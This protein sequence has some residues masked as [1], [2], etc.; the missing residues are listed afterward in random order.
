MKLFQILISIIILTFYSSNSFAIKIKTSG[1]E[2]IKN[3]DINAARKRA[4]INALKNA[5]SQSGDILINENALINELEINQLSTSTLINLN[6]IQIKNETIKNGFIKL[7]LEILIHSKN[8]FQCHHI[9]LKSNLLIPQSTI[10]NRAQL[11]FGNLQNFESNITEKFGDMLNHLSR[12][13]NGY[14]YSKYNLNLNHESSEFNSDI[15]AVWA[16][17]TKQPQY[18]LASNITDISLNRS[19]FLLNK[20]FPQYHR[21]FNMDFSLYHG[22]TGE[23]VWQSNYP[24]SAK[25][26]F[27]KNETVMPDSNEFWQSSYGKNIQ[28]IFSN[29][30]KDLDSFLD[31]KSVIGKVIAKN[32]QQLI[33]N[34]GR[35][36]G[37]KE[38]DDIEL[39]LNQNIV[40]KYGLVRPIAN[41]TN[42]ILNVNQVTELTASGTLTAEDAIENIQLNDF[43]I[44]KV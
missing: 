2:N 44:P 19:N 21:N 37:I 35:K 8:K 11:R 27:S 20:L 26:T 28:Q 40:D 16:A 13:S 14:V 15:I 4:F 36:H 41:K 32:Q 38:N 17:N 33:I 30:I 25:W 9:N 31:C 29:V 12:K 23:L 6:Q 5:N 18:I 3:N 7:D 24:S 39:V 1:F 10:D 42:V 34:L 43:A 22:I